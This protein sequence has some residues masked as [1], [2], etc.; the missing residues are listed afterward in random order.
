VVTSLE[1]LS[2]QMVPLLA[3]FQALYPDI[4]L[5][6][7][8]GERLFRLEYGEAHVAV[9]AGAP[10][11]QPDNIVQSFAAQKI[12]LYASTG[13]IA[14]HGRPEGLND[15]AKHR[16]VG[17]DQPNMRAA[18]SRWMQKNVPADRV[19]FR[20]NDGHALEQAILAGVGIGFLSELL[21]QSHSGL[22]EVHPPEADWDAPLWLVTHMD[23]H[24]TIKV[25]TF[26][27]FLKQQAKLWD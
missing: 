23:L 12:R 11:E 17:V 15:F 1:A 2:R 16:F 24:R 22:V 8:T 9:R 26:L 14:Q 21:A 7:L 3:E 25:Q 18:F 13:Y 10:P 20:S 6:Y 5:R 4:T 19:V 27:T